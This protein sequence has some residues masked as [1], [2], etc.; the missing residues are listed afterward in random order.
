LSFLRI[1]IAVCDALDFAHARNI[2]HLDVKSENVMVGDPWRKSISST[3]AFP[4]WRDNRTASHETEPAAAAHGR[5]RLEPLPCTPSFASPEQAQGRADKVSCRHGRV[6]RGRPALRDRDR[7]SALRGTHGQR[8]LGRGELLP[9]RKQTGRA[10]RS[11]SRRSGPRCSLWY[12][13]YWCWDSCKPSTIETKRRGYPRCAPALKS[14][15]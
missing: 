12:P 10:R 1:V 9:V 6:W 4:G 13:D 5:R 2:L 3:G 7:Q 11:D 15:A 14:E 8:S